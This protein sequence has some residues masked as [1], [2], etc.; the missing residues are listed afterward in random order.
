MKTTWTELHEKMNDMNYMNYIKK[1]WKWP[2]SGKYLG[3][4]QQQKKY[5]GNRMRPIS[6]IFLTTECFCSTYR[7]GCVN[8]V[9]DFALALGTREE[10]DPWWKQFSMATFHNRQ[11]M[12]YSCGTVAST[13]SSPS[14][15]D[16]IGCGSTLGRGL[17][18]GF[19]TFRGKLKRGRVFV[20]IGFSNIY[21]WTISKV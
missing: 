3:N 18:V 16:D 5:Y 9:E 6:V 10:M 15:G 17:G 1:L 14:W 11:A 13:W 12:V 8:I 21:Y 4:R 20:R 7:Q 19:E 2:I